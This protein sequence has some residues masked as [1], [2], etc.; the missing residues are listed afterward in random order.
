MASDSEPTRAENADFVIAELRA[1]GIELAEDSRLMRMREVA[2]RRYVD[3][4]DDEFKI[5]I[6]GDRD[7]VSLGFI[8][9]Q[10]SV[11]DD[12]TFAAVVKRL[13]HDA[14]VPQDE[15]DNSTPGRDAQFELYIAACCQKAG[16]E[17]VA[18]EEPD[19]TCLV[20]GRR[21][22]I[23]AK[24]VKCVRQ[25][26]KRIN[27]A[28]RQIEKSGIPGIIVLDMAIAWNPKN[29]PMISPLWNQMFDHIC[30]LRCQDFFDKRRDLIIEHGMGKGVV[31]VVAFDFRTR[32]VGHWHQHRT[33]DWFDMEGPAD[34]RQLF[35]SFYDGFC[36]VI[37]N[38]QETIAGSGGNLQ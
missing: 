22:C 8:L 37:P 6:E 1:L 30:D 26:S 17:P 13:I 34:E 15:T 27:A 38:R 2:H 23:A 21:F 18:Y 10:L 16:F 25:A 28:A 7:L 14:V 5:A 35:Q 4:H 12:P 36:A 33:A 29:V 11:R 31:G 24:R 9:E 32:Y 20:D 3:F 19:V